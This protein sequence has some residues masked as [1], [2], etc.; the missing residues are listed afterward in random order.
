MSN[1]YKCDSCGELAEGRSKSIHTFFSAGPAKVLIGFYQ[2]VTLV[3]VL[4]DLCPQCQY[5]WVSE[6]VAEMKPKEAK[7]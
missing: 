1:A 4:A 5:D 7:L 3:E 6:A 2:P